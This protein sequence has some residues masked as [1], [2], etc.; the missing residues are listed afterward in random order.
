MHGVSLEEI[1][2][3]FPNIELSYETVG[4][5]KVYDFILCIPEGKKVFAWFT[6]YKKQNVCFLMEINTETKQII[7]QA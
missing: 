1:I 7:N 2:K 5:N 3:N 6:T 4:H